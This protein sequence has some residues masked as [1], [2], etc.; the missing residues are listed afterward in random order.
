[1]IAAPVPF[2]LFRFMV[3]PEDICRN[4]IDTTGLHFADFPAPFRLRYAGIVNLAHDGNDMLAVKDKPLAIH[5]KS[6]AFGCCRCPK[7]ESTLC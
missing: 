2:S 4:D 7:P 3:N 5:Q 6:F 1:M